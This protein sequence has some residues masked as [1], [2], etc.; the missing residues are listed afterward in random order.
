MKATVG[1]LVNSIP[2]DTQLT[3][4]RGLSQVPQH[5]LGTQAPELETNQGHKARLYLA[6]Q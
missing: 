5:T 2:L 6:L 3:R 4:N 1:I